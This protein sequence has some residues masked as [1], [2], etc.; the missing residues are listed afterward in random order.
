MSIVLLL[1]GGIL[2]SFAPGQPCMDALHQLRTEERLDIVATDV[3]ED[4]VIAFTLSD[5]PRRAEKTALLVCERDLDTAEDEGDPDLA[6]EAATDG[7]APTGDALEP[8]D[9][10]PAPTDEAPAPTDAADDASAGA[11]DAEAIIVE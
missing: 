7:L 11:T 2:T 1:V 6:D 8:T 5:G 3:L 9:D 4:N 10:A